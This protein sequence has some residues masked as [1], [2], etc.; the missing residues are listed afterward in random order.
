[1]RAAAAAP[2]S[3]LIT[4]APPQHPP[5]TR[6]PTTLWLNAVTPNRV[7]D[8]RPKPKQ[9]RRRAPQ[10]DGALRVVGLGRRPRLE[11]GLHRRRVPGDAAGAAAAAAGARRGRSRR[12]G[13]ARGRAGRE[14]AARRARA[15]LHGARRRGRAGAGRRGR[16]R[17]HAA[18]AGCRGAARLVR[19]LGCLCL[20][21]RRVVMPAPLAGTPAPDDRACIC[22]VHPMSFGHSEAA[23]GWAIASRRDCVADAGDASAGRAT[24][25]PTLV[26]PPF[27]RLVIRL[28][29]AA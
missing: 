19:A 7:S 5:S 1:V 16:C 11:R 15:D 14:R 25:G 3:A 29:I 22:A 18:P 8:A 26:W 27:R 24:A 2:L 21:L 4:R 9:G 28:S 17:A 13:R 12:G 10:D 23:G 6:P 20:E